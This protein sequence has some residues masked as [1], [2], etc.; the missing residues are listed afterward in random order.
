MKKL[1]FFIIAFASLTFSCISIPMSIKN[2][3]TFCYTDIYTGIDTLINIDGHY[4][5]L[6]FYENGLVARPI[7]MDIEQLRRNDFSFIE[8]VAKNPETKES[9]SF[10][11]F[12]DCG[13]YVI[14]G[15]MIKV[16]MLH[17]HHSINDEW[18]GIEE[19]YKIIDK[20]TLLLVDMFLLTTN[21]NQR[22]QSRR[23]YKYYNHFPKQVTIA[24]L[25][26]KLPSEYH[27][28][29]KKKWF[30]CNKQ[31]WKERRNL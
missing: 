6:I 11:N 22:E 30:W 24:S 9:K 23:Q 27:W 5:A 21:K 16:Q 26:A 13:S 10:Y 18:D 8:K 20:N 12:I 7:Y 29:L 1:T 28:I 31:D 14:D 4:S 17:N 3:F 15:D 25:P 19:W 2:A